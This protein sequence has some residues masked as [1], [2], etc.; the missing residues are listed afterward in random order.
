LITEVKIIRRE[1]GWYDVEPNEPAG[2][3]ASSSCPSLKKALESAEEFFEYGPTEVVK[4]E[5]KYDPDEASE[6]GIIHV[7]GEC[8]GAIRVV[9]VIKDGG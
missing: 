9:N 6:E 5:I 4:L 2:M 7:V 3:H 1:N 8:S